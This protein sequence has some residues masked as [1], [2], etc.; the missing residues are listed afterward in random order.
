MS[1]K[2]MEVVDL[3]VGVNIEMVWVKPGTFLM[4]SPESDEGRWSD[5]GPQHE[6]TISQGFYFRGKGRGKE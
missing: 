2:A 5:E 6:V 4:G 1:K 3:S